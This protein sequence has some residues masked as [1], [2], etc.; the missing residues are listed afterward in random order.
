MIEK[1]AK[2]SKKNSM[3]TPSKEEME[4]H[5]GDIELFTKLCGKKRNVKKIVEKVKPVPKHE[6]STEVKER[7]KLSLI[8]TNSADQNKKRIFSLLG[9]FQEADKQIKP[10]STKKMPKSNDHSGSIQ[11]KKF[12]SSE[13]RYKSKKDSAQK[14]DSNTMDTVTAVEDGGGEP[15]ETG[16]TIKKK[17]KAETTPASAKKSLEDHK[18]ILDYQP[19]DHMIHNHSFESNSNSAGLRFD[20][21]KQLSGQ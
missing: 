16:Y 3:K 21:L 6:T 2:H 4:D 7:K 13:N 1:I 11:A 20:F 8:Q 17:V 9:P 12:N 15:D 14:E 18:N 19:L 5:P 10:T